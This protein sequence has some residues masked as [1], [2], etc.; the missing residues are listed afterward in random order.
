[1]EEL[2]SAM[3]NPST[4]DEKVA[5]IRMIQ[6]HISWVFLTGNFV[7]KIRKPV[8]FGFVDFSTLEKRRNICKKDVKLNSRLSSEIYLGVVPITE[9]DGKIKVNGEGRTIE[10]AVKMKE[11]PRE[12]KMD[13]LLAKNQVNIKTV[14]DIARIVADFHS[15]AETNSEIS[16]YGSIENIK[17]ITDENFD[18]TEEFIGKTITR[19]QFDFIKKKV[20]NFISNNSKLFND[21]ISRGKIKDCHGDLHSKNIFI[22]DKIYIFDC[23]EL[24]DGYRCSDVILDIAF[25]TMDLDFHNRQDLSKHFIEKYFEFSKEDKNVTLLRFYECWR[26]YVRGKVISFKLNDPNI[27]EDEKEESA[28][29]AKKYFALSYSYATEF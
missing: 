24:T 22:S 8:N 11:L 21:R 28:A 26:A 15:K 3:M 17:Y 27:D 29:L 6:T 9:S 19:E 13:V 1:M 10:Y 4:Y 12:K 7:Y 20:E 18:Q 23:C 14:E 2:I 16:K 5:S 25:L